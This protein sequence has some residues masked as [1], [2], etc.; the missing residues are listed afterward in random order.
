[1][2][3]L[4]LVVVFSGL[5]TKNM[6]M[7]ITPF[8]NLIVGEI[9]DNCININAEIEEDFLQEMNLD[10][11]VEKIYL[12]HSTEVRHIGGVGLIA[13]ICDDF[14]KVNNSNV[15]VEGR[16]PKYDNEIAIAAKYAKEKDL[17]IGEDLFY[18][19]G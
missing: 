8:I 7:D 9:A 15:V 5:M 6:I 4:S 1:M 16:F 18:L 19:K 13:T 12:Y 10:K 14:S 3:V 2:L 17:E 11:Q